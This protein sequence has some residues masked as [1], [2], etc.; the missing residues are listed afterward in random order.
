MRHTILVVA[1]LTACRTAAE[2][3][4][5]ILRAVNIVVHGEVEDARRD[6]DVLVTRDVGGVGFIEPAAASSSGS[7][8]GL[9]RG[10]ST[11]SAAT[12]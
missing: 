4:E 7:A 6:A 12:R 9:D 2:F 3:I 5:V 1:L 11:S 10:V 8:R